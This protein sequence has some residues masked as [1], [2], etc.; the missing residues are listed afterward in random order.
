MLFES[1]NWP[2]LS[3]MLQPLWKGLGKNYGREGERSHG[4][5]SLLGRETRVPGCKEEGRSVSA[6]AVDGGGEDWVGARLVS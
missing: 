5:S 6:S 2:N 4:S 3:E 1:W